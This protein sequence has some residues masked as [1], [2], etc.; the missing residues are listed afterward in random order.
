MQD[1]VNNM[2]EDTVLLLYGDHGMTTDGNHGGDSENEVRT[3]FFAYTKS[4]F[5]LLRASNIVNVQK[6]L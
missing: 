5:P 6:E 3:V 1:V 4:G 2:D